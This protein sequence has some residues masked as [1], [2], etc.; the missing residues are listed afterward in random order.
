MKFFGLQS[1]TSSRIFKEIS[2]FD[3]FGS[4]TL[5]KPRDLNMFQMISIK[6]FEVIRREN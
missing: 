1:R 3:K 6:L 4:A 5:P 2:D